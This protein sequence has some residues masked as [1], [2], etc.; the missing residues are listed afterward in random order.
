MSLTKSEVPLDAVQTL[1]TVHLPGSFAVRV[2]DD[3]PTD[4]RSVVLTPVTSPQVQWFTM[5]TPEK[6]SMLVQASIR[7]ATRDSCRLAGD[8]VRDVLTARVRGG[9]K[10]PLDAAGYVFDV[11]TTQGDGHYETT[12]GVNTWVETFRIAWQYRP[13]V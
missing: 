12:T 6:A 13:G 8:F 2:D 5:A 4:A 1:L 7:S 9:A 11:P 10:Y 3:D